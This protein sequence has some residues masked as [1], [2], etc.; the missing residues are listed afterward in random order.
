MKG[1][2]KVMGAGK[3][4]LMSTEFENDFQEVMKKVAPILSATMQVPTCRYCRCPFLKDDKIQMVGALKAHM[5]C[6]NRGQ[7]VYVVF[8]RGSL[9]ISLHVRMY[10]RL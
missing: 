4:E 1:T 3:L 9:R 8:Q 10:T 5:D 7:A 6:A 2:A